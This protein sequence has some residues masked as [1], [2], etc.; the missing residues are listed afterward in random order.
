VV[1]IAAAPTALDFVTLGIA[2][3]GA[4]TGV[5]ALAATWAQFTLSG[6]RLKVT[7]GVAFG[8]G[9]WLLAVTV[10]NEGR[11]PVTVGQVSLELQ[12]K[13]HIPIG[14]ELYHGR[15]QGPA[16]PLRLEPYSEA[17]WH[18]P[19]RQLWEGMQQHGHGPAVR[20]FVTYADKRTAAR[21]SIDLAQIA[22]LAE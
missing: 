13:D 11:M 22:S 7:G 1:D 19:A 14:L 8:G 3:V 2:A 6:P 9:P 21:K 18:L 15:A 20:P 10:L 5:A 16:I 17:T 4:I 12:S